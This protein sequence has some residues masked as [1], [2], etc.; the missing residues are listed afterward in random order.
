MP[1]AILCKLQGKILLYY[2][3]GRN[4]NRGEKDKNQGYFYKLKKL[5]SSVNR[6]QKA[7]FDLIKVFKGICMTNR[8]I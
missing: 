7:L 2:P 3:F 8:F 4:V 5:F 1:K 6:F